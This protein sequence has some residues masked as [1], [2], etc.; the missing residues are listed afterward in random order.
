MECYAITINTNRKLN[1]K[2]NFFKYRHLKLILDFQ[3]LR[4]CL[5][6]F[7][8]AL[9]IKFY[10]CKKIKIKKIVRFK[11]FQ[12]TFVRFFV[13]EYLPLIYEKSYI[14]R[15]CDQYIAKF[16]VHKNPVDPLMRTNIKMLSAIY[17]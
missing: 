7:Y 12:T 17:I 14:F 16:E 6:L 15:F 9:K 11:D 3:T 5:H 13:K 1:K 2:Y 10:K 4:K 8:C